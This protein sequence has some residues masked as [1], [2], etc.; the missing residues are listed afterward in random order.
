MIYKPATVT[1]VGSYAIL[2]STVDPR[3]IDTRNRPALAQTFQENATGGRF[4]VA[5]NHLKSKG[6]SCGVGDDDTTTGQGNC[7]GT[8]TLAAQ[9][10]ADWLATD[11]TGSGDPDMMIIG[12]LNSY[13]KEDP[14]VALQNAGYT[15]MVAAFGGPNAYSYVFDGQLGYLDHALANSSLLTQVTD[16]AEWHIN[17]DEIP[18]FDYNDDVRD[19]GEASF[20]EESDTLPLYEANAFRTS[21]H[22][23]VV[24]SLNPVNYPPELGDITVSSSLV[25]IGTMV[26]ASVPFT[27]PDALDTHTAVW[28]WGDGNT[29]AGIVMDNLGAGTVTGSHVYATPGIYTIQVTLQDNF[30]NSDQAIYEFIVVY[31]PSGGY[32]SGGGWIETSQGPGYFALNVRYKRNSTLPEGM[33]GF[34]LPDANLRL[35]SLS[36][37]WLVIATNRSSAIYQGSGLLNEALSPAGTPYKFKIWAINGITPGAPDAF[38]IRIWYVDVSGSTVV[39]FDNASPQPLSEGTIIV[40]K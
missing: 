15:D 24:I 8:R 37:D 29:T 14:I 34:K 7:N 1:P 2:D 25:T 17:A 4:T 10:L 23:P 6:S 30:G 26:D 11:P 13:A 38:R 21:D 9:A 27:D 40:Y 22:D 12:D 36:H 35:M 19:T 18:L 5:V 28:D 31:D 3:F 16:V 20:E 33:T 39:V 32:V